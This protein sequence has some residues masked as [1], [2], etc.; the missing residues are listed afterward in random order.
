MTH[1]KHIILRINYSINEINAMINELLSDKS[2]SYSELS[3]IQEARGALK[4]AME[5]LNKLNF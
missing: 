1:K 4:E 2:L 5:H 3:N